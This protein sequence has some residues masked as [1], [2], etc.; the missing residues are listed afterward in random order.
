M[1]MGLRLAVRREVVEGMQQVED[2]RVVEMAAGDVLGLLALE[3][4]AVEGEGED[5]AAAVVAEEEVGVVVVEEAL[6][7]FAII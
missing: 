5:A 3:L 4:E 7:Q 2:V 6:K 1:G